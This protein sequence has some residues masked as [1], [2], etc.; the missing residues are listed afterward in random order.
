MWVMVF[1]GHSQAGSVSYPASSR[2]RA[3][4]FVERAPWLCPNL[5]SRRL[6]AVQGTDVPVT[7]AVVDQREDLSGRGD[8]PD[9]L[10][11]AL[12]H[13]F[14]GGP[15]G[16]S[17]VVATDGLHRRPAQDVGALLGDVAPMHGLVRLLVGW[18][19]PGPGAEVPCG[20]EAMYV[21][22]LGH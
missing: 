13:P 4:S 16:V 21:S 2:R 10:A 19:Q 8:A 17:A 20:G 22:D 14:P 11:P 9:H 6:L 12:G 1:S 3:T 5:A 18:G 15:D 7:Q